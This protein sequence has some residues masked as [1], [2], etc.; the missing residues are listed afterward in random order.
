MTP[1]DGGDVSTI[2]AP[3]TAGGNGAVAIV[4]LSGPDALKIGSALSGA[5]LFSFPPRT[6]CK[7]A[8]R[9]ADGSPIDD[10]LAV[11][12]R[13]PHSFTG[14]DVVEFQ[15]HGSP[16]VVSRL[17]AEACALGARPAS[18]GEFS[19]RAFVNGKMDLAQAE[20]VADLI[21]ARTDAAACAA[22]RQMRGSLREAVGP[23]RD[24]L[25][26]AST[27][28]VAAIDFSDEEDVASL[29]LPDVPSLVADVRARLS[30]LLS[31]FER[32][33]RLRDGAT[34]A[35]VGA[36]N[37]G[38]SRLLNAIVGF[39]RAI[40]AD[41]PGTTRD[42][43]HADI[44]L[45]GVPVRLVDTAGLRDTDCVVEREG[46]RRTRDEIASADLLLFVVDG[47][48]PPTVD[49]TAVFDELAVRPHLLVVNKSDLP[50]SPEAT[51]RWASACPDSFVV[52]H[53]NYSPDSLGGADTGEG[54]A[55]SIGG[56][57][58]G[59]PSTFCVSAKTGEGVEA[60]LAAVAA[61]LAPTES[62]LSGEAVLTRV[63]HVDAIRSA[64]T[65]LARAEEAARSGLSHEFVA[66]DL[67]LA[68]VALGELT[69]EITP[70]DLLDAI[71]STFCVGK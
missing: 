29:G 63:R 12:F 69:G 39:E 65:A 3:A 13:A 59:V 50:A 38:K 22:V 31:T 18:A 17:C 37:V 71:F 64:Y 23:L 27:L 4:R 25:L 40:V 30:S 24:S 8:L 56:N 47:S 33:R 49:E 54:D 53:T 9:L 16:V 68:A 67:R 62:E 55:A 11:V 32:N 70:D 7:V 21:A 6:L 28:L 14:E 34:V 52:S 45:H 19:R 36:V 57:F 51:E 44:D 43:L 26:H 10:A 58:S 5:D 61:S 15:T 1:L 66:D 41:L 48:R 2:V 35:L 20:G 46:V 42:T 60:L